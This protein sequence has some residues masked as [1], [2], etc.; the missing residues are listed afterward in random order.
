MASRPSLAAA[1]AAAVFCAVAL[2]VVT[3]NTKGNYVSS[4]RLSAVRHAA[5]GGALPTIKRPLAPRSAPPA[6]GVECGV[7]R[8]RRKKRKSS[9]SQS[10]S[11]EDM[12][13]DTFLEKAKAEGMELPTDAEL[14]EFVSKMHE[15]LGKEPPAES[16]QFK[17]LIEL[18]E[19]GSIQAEI[20]GIDLW[21][22]KPNPDHPKTYPVLEVNVPDIG[23]TKFA[24]H[25]GS[26]LNIISERLARR[27]GL[28]GAEDVE[29]D[30]EEEGVTRREVVELPQLTL[31]RKKSPMPEALLQAAIAPLHPS[32]EA[33]DVQGMLGTRFLEN[34]DIEMEFPRMMRSDLSASLLEGKYPYIR[35]SSEGI[36]REGTIRLLPPGW[37]AKGLEDFNNDRT[38]GMT[39]VATLPLIG[40]IPAA[41]VD[42]IV[43]AEKKVTMPA[44]IDLGSPF[45]MINEKACDELGIEAAETGITY[46]GAPMSRPLQRIRIPLRATEEAGGKG[47]LKPIRNVLIGD[48]GVFKSLNLTDTPA[49]L[50]GM[51]ILGGDRAYISAKSQK[52]WLMP[53]RQYY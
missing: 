9:W 20:P 6:R 30:S 14:R 50:I 17:E 7:K 27:L 15:V 53:Q 46:A 3:I 21:R 51:D 23:P 34:Y 8:R 32:M 44:I 12:D 10:E 18:L 2:A 39:Q 42:V 25:T 43:N 38:K 33:A 35:I 47:E 49:A 41:I 28:G 52:M 26:N 19:I 31:G 40:N 48:A 16:L 37:V 4:S 13:I 29:E 22:F 36:R 11:E 45:S 5:P 24:I 1:A